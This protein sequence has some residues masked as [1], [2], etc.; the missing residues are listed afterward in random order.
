M[1]RSSF[2]GASSGTSSHGSSGRSSVQG[3]RLHHAGGGLEDSTT[4]AAALHLSQSTAAAASIAAESV[5]L[6]EE[7]RLW[8]ARGAAVATD[9]LTVTRSGPSLIQSG[10]SPF[11]PLLDVWREP[12]VGALPSA[13]ALARTAALH[14]AAAAAGYGGSGLA[15]AQ[16]FLT[17]A[18]ARGTDVYVGITTRGYIIVWS[19]GTAMEGVVGGSISSALAA[20]VAS[21]APRPPSAIPAGSPTAAA[22]A[23]AAAASVAASSST[24]GAIGSGGGGDSAASYLPS[25]TRLLDFERILGDNYRTLIAAC[26]TLPKLSLTNGGAGGGGGGN[27]AQHQQQQQ[28]QQQSSQNG[29][30]NNS[31]NSSNS[32]KRG[33]IS[34]FVLTEEGHGLTYH[35]ELGVI[36]TTATVANTATTTQQQA[37]AQGAEN[38]H[39]SQSNAATTLSGGVGTVSGAAAAAAAVL[40]SDVLAAPRRVGIVSHRRLLLRKALYTRE[41]M[42]GS[43]SSGPAGGGGL[44]SL[45]ANVASLLPVSHPT[46]VS[47]DAL[48]N[49]ILLTVDTEIYAFSEATLQTIWQANV[50]PAIIGGGGSSNAAATVA[51]PLDGSSGEAGGSS[52]SKKRA[53]ED[54]VAAASSTNSHLRL[55]AK[56]KRAHT[57]TALAFASPV[58]GALSVAPPPQGGGSASS[59]SSS[60]GSSA[61]VLG[62]PPPSFLIVGTRSGFVL[63]ITLRRREVLGGAIFKLVPTVHILARIN[64]HQVHWHDMEMALATAA[65]AEAGN[66]AAG[67]GGGSGSGSGAANGSNNSAGVTGEQRDELARKKEEERRRKAGLPPNMLR[68]P[69]PNHHQQQSSAACAAACC[70]CC[71]LSSCSSLLSVSIVTETAGRIC[72]APPSR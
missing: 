3:H 54:K 31:S 41:S 26:F 63:C 2:S 30:S 52:S 34:L 14:A 21:P 32:S 24:A 23:A 5:T 40:N 28:Q 6:S 42:L 7:E 62:A 39:A 57:I 46:N 67:S 69:Q 51:A 71:G 33:Q 8:L 17:I 22:A 72:A 55:D 45:G 61:V 49:C 36:A 13:L 29:S 58:A 11:G 4:A 16:N 25:D 65:A 47:Y 10:L 12:G 18:E 44:A 50:G 37:Q 19:Q 20:A 43:V 35:I 60:S 48:S 66:G 9:R 56:Q 53:A 64:E 70:C 68:P 27:S 15:P 38:K 1:P 59:A